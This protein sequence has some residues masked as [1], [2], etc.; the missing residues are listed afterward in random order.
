MLNQRSLLVAGAV[1]VAALAP[2]AAQGAGPAMDWTGPYVGAN[3]GYGWSSSNSAKFSVVDPG[4]AW[5]GP[6][7]AAGSCLSRVSYDRD[8]FVGGA[9]VGYNWQVNQWVFGLEADLDYSDMNGGTTVGTAVGAFAPFVGSAHSDIDWLST[10]RGRLGL[11]FGSALVYATAGFAGGSVEDS[12][13]W[14]YPGLGQ[15]YVGRD[16]G[17]EWGWTAGGGLEYAVSK[18]LIVGGEVLYFDLGDTTVPGIPIAGF[19]P[20]AGTA[21]SGNFDHAGVIARARV[22]YK[23]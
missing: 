7:L 6:C 8:G 4:G 2:L 14:G 3:L 13:S 15:V 10:I 19:T 23:F 9:Q 5:F 17:T 20:P 22:S 12:F 1:A 18:N 16:S 11:A 21:L